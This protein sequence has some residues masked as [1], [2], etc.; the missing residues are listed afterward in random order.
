MIRAFPAIATALKNN[1]FTDIPIER[2]PDFI[3]LVPKVKADEIISVRFVPDRFTG[4]R[5]PD[6]F[7]TPDLDEIRSVV[8]QVLVLPP[9]EA[10]ER[11]SLE[12]IGEACG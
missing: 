12:D 4:Q 2:L 7:P 11:L 5:T 9:G 6:R 1:L 8:Q 10:L 3:E